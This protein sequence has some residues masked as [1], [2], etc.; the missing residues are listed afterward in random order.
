ML[1]QRQA[2]R[3]SNFSTMRKAARSCPAKWQLVLRMGCNTSVL[4]C[5]R[6]RIE[7]EKGVSS[8]TRS[9][10]VTSGTL[11]SSFPPSWD[12]SPYLC[13]RTIF[14]ECM[15][16]MSHSRRLLDIKV[17]ICSESLLNRK[18]VHIYYSARLSYNRMKSLKSVIMKIGTNNNSNISSVLYISTVVNLENVP[19]FFSMLLTTENCRYSWKITF[20]HYAITNLIDV[21]NRLK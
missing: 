10:L 2:R 7:L 4:K 15:Y 21:I 9:S 13:F 16:I 12:I 6:N 18:D 3:F 11:A 20:Y 5:M 8:G 17:K 14:R 19:F 1:P